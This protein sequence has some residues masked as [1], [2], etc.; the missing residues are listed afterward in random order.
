MGYKWNQYRRYSVECPFYKKEDRQVIYCHGVVENSS[1][2]LA[3]A[4]PAECKAYKQK[5]CSGNYKECEVYK[6]LE[7]LNNE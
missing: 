3:F 7:E 5:F 1:I 2:H 4:L 6:M